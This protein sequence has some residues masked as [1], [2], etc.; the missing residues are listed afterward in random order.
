MFGKTIWLPKC[1]VT[2]SRC[3]DVNPLH[4]YLQMLNDINVKISWESLRCK[5][6]L[7]QITKTREKMSQPMKTVFWEKWGYNFKTSA[8]TLCKIAFWNKQKQTMRSEKFGSQL[9]RKSKFWF[10][11][12]LMCMFP[13]SNETKFWSRSLHL[14]SS[15]ILQTRV[16]ERRTPWKWILAIFKYKNE[17][18]R[19]LELK[20]LMKKTA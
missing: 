2:S 13:E 20:K 18:R 17:Y 16:D 1:Q 14:Q 9:E 10:L 3:E 8:S 19:Q 4:F 5:F 6:Q 7:N 12:S 15:G 11:F